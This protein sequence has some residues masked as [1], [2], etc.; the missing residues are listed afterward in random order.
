MLCGL[1]VWQ[2][3]RLFWKLDLIARVEARVHADPV[4]AP[5][6]V[7]WPDIDATTDEYRRVRVTGRLLNDR[8]TLVQA[9]TALGPGYWVLT[10]LRTDAGETVLINRGF[11]P[12]ERRDPESRREG[13]LR[14]P[15]TVTGLLRMAEPKGGFLRSNDPAH[16]RWYSRDVA[17]IAA[18]RGLADVAPFFIDA[19]GTAN[20]GGWPVGGLTVVQF[21]NAHAVYA[22]TWF[23]LAAMLAGA[24]AWVVR[25]ER[26]IRSTPRVVVVAPDPPSRRTG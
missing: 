10:P 17:A 26:R 2:V 22:F 19:D 16:D 15:V 20:P 4:P 11:V 7:T 13:E 8:E 1:G 3:H 14:D 18:T 25:D 24:V 12:P 9:L 5:A 23:T 21:R 6:P